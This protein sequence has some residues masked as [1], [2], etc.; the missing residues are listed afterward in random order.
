[1]AGQIKK[2]IDLIVEK[3]TGNNQVLINNMKTKLM[4][5]GINPA[6]YDINS[7]DDPVILAKLELFAQESNIKL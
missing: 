5:R 6:K 2:M 3:K 4:L 7:P 1:L